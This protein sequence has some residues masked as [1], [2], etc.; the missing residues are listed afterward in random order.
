MKKRYSE[1]LKFATKLHVD[2]RGSLRKIASKVNTTYKLEG[3]LKIT[4]KTLCK[5]RDPNH[6]EQVNSSL[7]KQG[8]KL[9]LPLVFLELIHAMV[10]VN[11]KNWRP[12]LEQQLQTLLRRVFQ[13]TTY[14][15]SFGIDF[16]TP[17][18][19]LR[20]CKLRIAEWTGQHIPV[21]MIGLTGQSNVLSNTDVL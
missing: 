13:G 17:N 9:L 19:N 16:P 8:L 18:N 2:D 1:A 5:Y 4:H 21:S 11:Q 14:T 3:K 20:Q 6:P 15:S 10:S 12:S 7:M